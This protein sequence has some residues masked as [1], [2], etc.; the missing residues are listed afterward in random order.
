MSSA[1]EEDL[2]EDVYEFVIHSAREIAIKVSNKEV[3]EIE[4]RDGCAEISPSL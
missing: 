2:G 1:K 4:T 3:I